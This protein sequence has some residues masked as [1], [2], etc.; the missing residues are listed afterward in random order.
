MKVTRLEDL[1]RWRRHLHKNPELSQKEYK[2]AAYIRAELD[3]MGL[4]YETCLNTGTIVYIDG[5]GQDTIILRADIDALPIREMNDVDFKSQNDGIMHACGHDAHASM[6]LGVVKEILELKKSGLLKVNILAVFQPSEESFG[7][8][9]LLIKEYDF[10]KYN[11]KASYALHVNPDFEEG[12]IITRPGPIMAS[13]N[14]FTIDVKGRTAHVG[15]RENGLNALNACVNIY[16]QIEAITVYDLDCKHTNIIHV[17]KMSVG[18]V[19]NAVPENGH[20]EGTIRTYDSSD[21]KIIKNRMKEICS[22]LEIASRCKV[23]LEFKEGYPALL[24]DG[25]LLDLVEKAV[26]KTGAS[27]ELKEEPYLLG[28]DFSFFSELGPVN[29]SFVGIRNEDL[30]YTTGLHTPTLQMREEAL[31]YGV[32]FLVEVVRAYCN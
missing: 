27:F 12:K 21:L 26:E 17:G 1:I 2:T 11:I 5:G 19:M 20:M 28:E 13:C 31:V 10:K 22:G 6:L 15:L 9:N 24:N 3:K 23:D 30:G 7:G 4:T 32:D 29:Y 18:E 14:E 16:Q 8:A 25:C